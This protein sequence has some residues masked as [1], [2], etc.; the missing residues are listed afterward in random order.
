M[1]RD[2][3]EVSVTFGEAGIVQPAAFNASK[4]SV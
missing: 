4:S 1:R 3:S 2:E